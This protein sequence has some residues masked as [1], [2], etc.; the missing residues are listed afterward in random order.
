MSG[1]STEDIHL[2]DNINAKL[3]FTDCFYD[4]SGILFYLKKQKIKLVTSLKRIR[5]D[6]HDYK[7]RLYHFRY[8]VKN[9]FLNLKRWRGIST[10]YAKTFDAFIASIFVRCIFMLF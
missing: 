1:V 5:P 2:I 9:T 3:I 4:T 8:I 10:R 7:R 6:Q